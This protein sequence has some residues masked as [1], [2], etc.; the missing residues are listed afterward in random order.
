[1]LFYH[2]FSHLHTEL[3]LGI[4]L[5][6]TWEV[7]VYLLKLY[8]LYGGQREQVN[9]LPDY[10]DNNK[11]DSRLVI[12]SVYFYLDISCFR[13]NNRLLVTGKDVLWSLHKRGVLFRVKGLNISL[14]TLD[15]ATDR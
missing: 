4:Q 13:R 8:I 12:K 15:F 6:Y 2:R 11:F 14:E 1:M 10:L 3:S 7:D 5:K 9:V